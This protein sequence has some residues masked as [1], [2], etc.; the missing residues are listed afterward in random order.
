MGHQSM[1]ASVPFIINDKILKI[2]NS[3]NDDFRAIKSGLC[4]EMENNFNEIILLDANAEGSK[5]G[6]NF[7]VLDYIDFPN[8]RILIS[9]GL[10]KNDI[11]KA[12]EIGLA[13]V[14]IDNFSL[15][16]E[17]SIKGLR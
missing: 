12:K 16:S 5:N 7:E 11:N 14:S 3:K 6:F 9:G 1:V 8:D 15:H 13:G 2:Y 10:T 17:Y 4:T